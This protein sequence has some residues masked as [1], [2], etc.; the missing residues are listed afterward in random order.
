[1]AQYITTISKYFIVIFIMLYTL[2]CFMVFRHKDEKSRR[3]TYAT[4]VLLIILT[5]F[6]SF[7][8]ICLRSGDIKYLFFYIVFQVMMLLIVEVFPMIYPRLNRL[9]INNSCMLLSIGLIMLTRLDFDKAVKQL[10]ISVLSFFVAAFIPF[11]M[12]KIKK[13]PN[14]PYI[15]AGTGLSL[16]LLVYIFGAI[17]NGSKLSLVIFGISFQ[18]S[19][20][21]KILFVLFVAGALC[22]ETNLLNLSII[23][24]I[25]ALHVVLLAL[26]ADLGAALIYFVI[27]VLLVFIATRNYLYLLIG[28]GTGVL[29][30]LIAYKLFR[31]VRVRVAAFLDPFTLIDNEGYQITQSLFAIS[32]GSFFGL[33]LFKG[34]PE[35]IPYVETD[36]IFSAISQEF[37]IV[38]AI[39]IVLICLS[40]F[41]QFINISVK[42]KDPFYRYTAIGLGITYIFQVF[43]T[44]GGGTKFIPLT[45]VTL[46]LISYGGS[47][48]MAT[49]L[50]FFVIEGMYV[51]RNKETYRVKF[52]SYEEEN[53]NKELKIVLGISYLFVALFVALT[54]YLVHTVYRNEEAYIN[55]SYNPRQEVLIT[56]NKRGTI[57]SH[58]MQV[59]AE[60]VT[61]KGEEKRFYPYYNIFSHVVGYASNGRA[62]VEGQANYYLINSNQPLTER[63]GADITGNKYLADSVVTTLDVDLQKVAYSAIGKY[64][65]AVVVT[66][67][68]TGAILAMVSKP[69]FNPNEIDAIWDDLLADKESSVL[70]NRATQGL[71]PPGS[72]F[73]IVTL[74]E[75]I[76]EHPD[77]Y[78]KYAFYCNGTLETADGTISCFNHEK[79]GNV[80]LKKSLAKSCNSSFGNIGLKLNYTDFNKTLDELLFNEDLPLT[81]N[82]SKS[83]CYIS[84]DYNELDIVRT[85][86][87]Q[88]ETLMSPMHLNMITQAIG[89]D[90]ILMKPYIVES[91]INSNETTVKTFSEK[92]YKRLL[93]KEESD[94]L[95]DM[96]TEVINSGTAK[97]LKNNNYT[98]AGKTGSAE[99]SDYS[100]VTHSWFTG[101]APADDPE[102]CVTIILEESGLSGTYAVPMAE[103]I[104]EEYFR[105]SDDYVASDY[106]PNEN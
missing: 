74:L 16:L 41:L 21:V 86:F 18:A 102:I 7:L 50:T 91:V 66:N 52:T 99:F 88:G 81:M 65:G 49:I 97:K 57:Y 22:H 32:S 55:N 73:K 46:P 35:T 14:R 40:C 48:V 6:A 75:Y 12:I 44:V 2:E 82:Y 62:G 84:D 26:S 43:L 36:F 27:Y 37:G 42:F 68:K 70:L 30:A 80:D 1:M 4:Q 3:L 92:E 106:N 104:F 96:M 67:P 8:T 29:A 98:I 100:T 34:T 45:G 103:R 19:E 64:D 85:A 95:T 17:T 105:R 51:T 72:T 24:G 89:N 47:S 79:H 10:I 54:I 58:D 76:R 13:I 90:G 31:H 93:S 11:V 33:G 61:E 78:N 56:E 69:D 87:G 25:A 38:F 60:T 71:Y 94:I 101:F 15:Y 9:L 59:L 23:S 83:K 53:V 63:I 5:H 28:S 39:C 77:D 20:F